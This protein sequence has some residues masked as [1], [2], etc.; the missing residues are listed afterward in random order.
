MQPFLQAGLEE[1]WIDAIDLWYDLDK[2]FL[3]PGPQ[4]PSCK[5]TLAPPEGAS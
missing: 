2:L 4:R 1:S 5:D 3:L